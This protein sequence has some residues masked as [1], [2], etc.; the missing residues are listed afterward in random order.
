[1]VKIQAKFTYTQK[2]NYKKLKKKIQ[3]DQSYEILHTHTQKKSL[4]KDKSC[5]F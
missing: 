2:R 4:K 1:M 3:P 5:L